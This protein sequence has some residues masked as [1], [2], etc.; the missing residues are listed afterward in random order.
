MVHP[1][2]TSW[3]AEE[4]SNFVAH[5]QRGGIRL[6][7]PRLPWYAPSH[8]TKADPRRIKSRAN[9]RPHPATFPVQFVERCVKLHGRCSELTVLD[10]FLGI[11]NSAVAARRCGVAKFIGIELDEEYLAVAHGRTGLETRQLL[12][13]P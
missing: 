3:L 2:S 6:Y 8:G 1:I 7:D 5:V 4:Q 12:S 9:Q 11:G 13:A 10:P